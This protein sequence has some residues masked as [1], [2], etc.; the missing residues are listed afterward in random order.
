LYHHVPPNPLFLIVVIEV[1]KGRGK[2]DGVGKAVVTE[3]DIRV[4]EERVGSL[5]TA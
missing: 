3:D 4:G 2:G 1:K 5:S